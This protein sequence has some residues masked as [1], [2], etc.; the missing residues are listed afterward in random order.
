M[1]T[2]G[3]LAA[4][5]LFIRISNNSHVIYPNSTLEYKMVDLLAEYDLVD[6]HYQFDTIKINQTCTGAS[7]HQ[8]PQQS[9]KDHHNAKRIP[10]T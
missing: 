9:L 10:P 3:Y 4:L 6:F 5:L 1:I 8:D 7:V 2:S